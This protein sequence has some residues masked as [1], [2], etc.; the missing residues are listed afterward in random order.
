MLKTVIEYPYSIEMSHQKAEV[1]SKSN[2][3]TFLR[4]VDLEC[5]IW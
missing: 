1:V 2:E 5:C 4:K 3:L